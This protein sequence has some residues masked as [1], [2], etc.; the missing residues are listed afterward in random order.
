MHRFFLW[1][2][3]RRLSFAFALAILAFSLRVSLS[4]DRAYA[5]GQFVDGFE[6]LPLMPGLSQ[7]PGR[8]VQ[9]DSAFGRIIESWATGPVT[10]EAVEAF[11][12]STLP[13]LGWVADGPGRFHR[14]GDV[15]LL[16]ARRKGSLVE[17][18]YRDSPPRHTP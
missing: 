7:E 3:L 1:H 4:V 11:Y 2:F 17:V 12:Q 13:Q 16:D 5:D 10:R 18:H 14:E 15:L 9:F 6:D 8:L